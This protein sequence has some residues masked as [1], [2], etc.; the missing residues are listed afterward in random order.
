MNNEIKQKL[1]D[2]CVDVHAHANLDWEITLGGNGVNSFENI[3]TA[4]EVLRIL[5]VGHDLVFNIRVEDRMMK[6]KSDYG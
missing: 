4:N 6:L 5:G 2:L 1:I 3:G